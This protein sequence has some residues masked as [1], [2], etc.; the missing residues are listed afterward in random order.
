MDAWLIHIAQDLVF[1]AAQIEILAPDGEKLLLPYGVDAGYFQSRME[2]L[3]TFYGVII[4]NQLDCKRIVGIDPV[5]QFFL[6]AP[7]AVI[8]RVLA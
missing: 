1:N 8:G 5:S 2:I 3:N 6:A 4:S 7:V